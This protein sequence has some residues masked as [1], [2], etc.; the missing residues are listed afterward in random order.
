[1]KKTL[2]VVSFGTSHADAEQ[3]CILP[4]EAALREAFPDWEV[5]RAWTSRRIVQKLAANGERIDNE[6]EAIARAKA[7]GSERIA[8][9][10]THIIRGHEYDMA[11]DACMS[12]DACDAGGRLP[13]SAPLLDTDAD[14]AWMAGLLGDIAL[15]TGGT[16][17]VMGHGTEHSADDTYDCLRGF[18]PERVKLA[19]VE[20]AH[21]LDGMMDALE[22]LPEKKLTLMPLMLVAGD[23]AKNDMAGEAEDS[24][25][26][27]LEARGF[28]V[29]ARMQGLGSLEAVRRRFVEKARAVI[30]CGNA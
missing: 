1:M 6:L 18:L 16:L 9:V 24:W 15:E 23:H 7:S 17:L 29:S 10:S 2:I 4:V 12:Y 14:L 25:K 28:E 27:R 13:I 22:A 21:S 8:L 3:S 19:C 11:C 30:E 26:C 20:G 5:R